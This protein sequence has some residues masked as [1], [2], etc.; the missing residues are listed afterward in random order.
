MKTSEQYELMKN[1]KPFF[2]DEYLDRIQI[3]C[4]KQLKK[5]DS[6]PYG[7]SKRNLLLKKMFAAYGD[8]NT[9]KEGFKCT[10][11]SNISIGNDCFL[12]FNVTILD[13][14]EVVIGNN[15]WIAPN[16]V[17][18]SVTHSIEMKDRQ[19]L[20]GGK[21]I[22]EDNVWIGA[23][24]IILPKVT[25]GKGAVIGAGAVVTK[26]VPANTV[27]AGVPAKEIKKIKN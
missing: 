25:I 12:N 16:V 20:K 5:L 18:S 9:V 14:Y 2:Y 1:C 11:G 6:T 3:N 10:L 22:I 23:G 21:T 19:N 7:I 8:N 4:A 13:S 27:V 26:D 15:V 24:A 17:I